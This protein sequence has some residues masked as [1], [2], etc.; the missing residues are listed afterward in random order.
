MRK[1]VRLDALL[2][3]R[4]LASNRS[5]A[6]ALIMAGKVLLNDRPSTK[7]GAGVDPASSLEL[8]GG[9]IKYVSRGGEKL[10]HALEHFRIR[11]KDAVA[12]DVGASTGGFTDCLLQREAKRVYCVDVGY[13]QL[14]WKLRQDSRVVNLERTNARH[15]KPE[16]IGEPIGLAV[17]DV[18]FI[19]LEL[20][21]PPVF[22][23]LS[24]GGDI[25]ALIK[26]QFEVGK[27]EVGKGGVVR[28]A[29]KHE[30]VLL[31]VAG[32]ASAIGLSVEGFTASPLKGPKGNSE[33]FI[34]LKKDGPPQD[35][36]KVKLMI[37]EVVYN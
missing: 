30:K 10:E 1:K 36:E 7:A 4:E 8:R 16:S 2:V 23:A 19:S 11:V 6:R 27:G 26:P 28:D 18:S 25:V 9:G 12:L 37:T 22:R 21:L 32:F 3:E 14:A 13:G 29:E 20:I 5:Q 34:R 24:E 31:K 33:F 35:T 17:I 15:L